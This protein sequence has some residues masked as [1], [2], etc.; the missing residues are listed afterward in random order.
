[1]LFFNQ[2]LREHESSLAFWLLWMWIAALVGTSC[3]CRGI[4]QRK[5][6]SE[7]VAARQLSL[8]GA[9]ALQRSRQQDAEMLFSEALRRSPIDERAHWGYASTLWSRGDRQRA[10]EHMKEALRLSGKN[11]EYA[12]RLGEMNLEMGDRKS[13]SEAAKSVLSANR[14]H[15]EA[16]AL[17]GDTHQSERDWPAALEC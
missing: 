8:K 16:W 2:Q 5:S 3:G 6:N 15:A 10:M 13:A 1:M 12:I 4:V 14:N 7:L 17:L 9:D 11:P